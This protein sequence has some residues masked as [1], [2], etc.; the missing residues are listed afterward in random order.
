MGR[1]RISSFAEFCRKSDERGRVCPD[2]CINQDLECMDC[3]NYSKYYE[4]D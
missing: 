3:V 4:G 2:L 1:G